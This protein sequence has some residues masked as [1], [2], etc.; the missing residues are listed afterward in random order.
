MRL[1]Y[2]I[3]HKIRCPP[4]GSSTQRGSTRVTALSTPRDV[5][6][7]KGRYWIQAVEAHYLT[8]DRDTLKY[9]PQ[10]TLFAVYYIQRHQQCFPHTRVS[11][12]LARTINH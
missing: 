11:A 9:L 8:S 3:Q 10:W 12:T 1:W 6:V 5:S 2:D 7:P 4:P